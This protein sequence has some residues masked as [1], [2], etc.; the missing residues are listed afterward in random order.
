MLRRPDAH[1]EALLLEGAECHVRE[2]RLELHTALGSV[3]PRPPHCFTG[4]QAFVEHA[5]G[6]LDQRPAKPGSAGCADRELEAVASKNEAWS[7]HAA[8]PVTRL[9]RPADE[10]GF[11]EHAVQVQVETG[12]VVPRAEPEAGS[13]DAGVSLR[14]D[15]RDVG[16]VAGSVRSRAV[17][18]LGEDDGALS[19]SEP[20]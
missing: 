11:A 6:D 5:G 18:K 4:R 12:N 19:L 20:L 16:R 1:F 15:D 7:H 8:H 13:E 14:V 10:V 3:Q 9:E 2:A 17:E